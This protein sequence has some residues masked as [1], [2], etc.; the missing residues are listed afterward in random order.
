MGEN[1]RFHFFSRFFPDKMKQF[2]S[3]FQ[4][5]QGIDQDHPCISFQYYRVAVSQ[6][7]YVPHALRHLGKGFL[8]IP[9]RKILKL[10]ASVLC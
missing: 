7:R 2:F 8:K 6:T 5:I 3:P 9:V 10:K 1:Y 4:R